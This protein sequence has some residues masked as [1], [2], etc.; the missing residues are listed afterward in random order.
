M[1]PRSPNMN[2]FAEA[3]VGA[4]KR[5]CMSHFLIFGVRHLEYL[6]REY[7]AYFHAERPHQGLGNRPP[8]QHQSPAEV[9]QLDLDEVVCHQRLGG[10]LRHYERTA[11]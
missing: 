3:W 6:I 4:I 11:A 10:L 1:P 5:G 8:N 2:P 9:T 7:L